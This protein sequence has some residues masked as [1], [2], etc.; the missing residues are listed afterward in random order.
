M[1]QN[2][3]LRAGIPERHIPELNF[4]FNVVPLLHRQGTV[5]HF[6]GQIQKTVQFLQVFVVLPQLRH[7]PDHL[8]DGVHETPHRP[9]VQNVIA[10]AEHSYKRFRSGNDK[11]RQIQ[12]RLLQNLRRAVLYNHF[13]VLCDPPR[14]QQ[15][16]LPL[17]H[18]HLLQV[19]DS[20]ILPSDLLVRHHAHIVLR[21]RFQ[22]RAHLLGPGSSDS[23]S[24]PQA[25]QKQQQ[26]RQGTPGRID[27][28]QKSF[29][30][31]IRDDSQHGKSHPG[32]DSQVKEIACQIRKAE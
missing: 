14:S 11:N 20:H 12:K 16:P 2:P 1:P 8:G 31:H 5:V 13:L 27:P 24:C 25:A 4:I 32:G 15:G 7:R 21:Q 29:H 10:Y 17:L 30:L 19:K 22:G 26:E 9:P 18:H 6:I 28:R 3:L 23:G